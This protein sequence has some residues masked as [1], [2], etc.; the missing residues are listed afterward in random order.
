PLRHVLALGACEQVSRGLTMSSPLKL[1]I[2]PAVEAERL[3]ALRDAAPEMEAVNAH[4]AEEAR[5]AVAGADAFFGKITPALLAAAG[6]LGC[7]HAPAASR[8]PSLFPALAEHPCVLTNMRGLFSDVI[9]DHVLGFV[10]CFAR[11]FPHYF[12]PQLAGHWEPV[13]GEAGRVAFAS[14]P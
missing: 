13:G 14:G 3:R 6:R 9:A 7:V 11:N 12:L 1:L 5:E 8:E 2:H 10:L 4:T